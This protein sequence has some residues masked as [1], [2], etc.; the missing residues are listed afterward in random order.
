MLVIYIALNVRCILES[1]VFLSEL[2]LFLK[3]GTIEKVLENRTITFTHRFYLFKLLGLTYALLIS[4]DLCKE[5][6]EQRT[7]KNKRFSETNIKTMKYQQLRLRK[8][9]TKVPMCLCCLMQKFLAKFL[10][11]S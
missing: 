2:L 6:I 4:I 7:Y 11:K 1:N 5:T 10:K 8:S 3:V 9:L